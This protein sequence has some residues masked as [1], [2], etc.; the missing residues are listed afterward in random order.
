MIN[1]HIL[2]LILKI[3]GGGGEQAPRQPSLLFSDAGPNRVKTTPIFV[4]VVL[5][6]IVIAVLSSRSVKNSL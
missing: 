1:W 4:V 3:T 5:E 6:V 2:I